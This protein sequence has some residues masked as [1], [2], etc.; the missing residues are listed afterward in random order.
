M[1]YRFLLLTLGLVFFTLFPFF[2][3]A[4][5]IKGTDSSLAQTP[6]GP[7]PYQTNN[8]NHAISNPSPEAKS[9]SNSPDQSST[10]PPA[11]R[12]QEG[13]HAED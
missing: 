8:P 2:S 3:Q 12:I 4:D 9:G 10:A 1:E 5:E 6:K 11:V 13:T 7:G